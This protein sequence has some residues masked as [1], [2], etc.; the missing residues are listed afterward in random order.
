MAEFTLDK[1]S[2]ADPK[3]KNLEELSIIIAGLIDYA[4]SLEAR[5]T[6]LG[7]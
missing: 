6:A 3:N 7:G 2:N 5:I 4:N 1:W